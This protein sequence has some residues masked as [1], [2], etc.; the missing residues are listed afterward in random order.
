MGSSLD[1]KN[2][3]DLLLFDI[4]NTPIYTLWLNAEQLLY[5]R[6]VVIVDGILDFEKENIDALQ[7]TVR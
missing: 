2:K 3:M 4:L 6:S 5:E 7:N 1:N